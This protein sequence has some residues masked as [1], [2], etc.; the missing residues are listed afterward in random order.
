MADGRNLVVGGMNLL[1]EGRKL[2]ADERKLVADGRK[3]LAVG[4]KKRGHGGYRP[5]FRVEEGNRSVV[6]STGVD[7]SRLNRVK[8][9]KPYWTFHV[10]YH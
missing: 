5:T 1:A 7:P 6:D 4:R 9:L 8:D 10:H 3:S 2:V